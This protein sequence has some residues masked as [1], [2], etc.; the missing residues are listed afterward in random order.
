MAP[1]APFT[2]QTRGDHSSSQVYKYHVNSEW[3]TIL[4]TVKESSIY[5]IPKNQIFMPSSTWAGHP[6]PPCGRPH[7]VDMKHT[8]RP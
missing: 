6:F 3:M 4:L 5:D 1:S 7:R 2:L 8:S